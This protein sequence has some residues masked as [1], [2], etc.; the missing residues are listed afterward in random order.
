MTVLLRAVTEADI[1]AI[2]AINNSAVPAVPF[3]DEDGIADLVD[4]AALKLVAVPDENPAAVLGFVLAMSSGS[5][6]DSENFQWFERRGEAH[7]YVDRIVV[8]DGARGRGVGEALYAAV[9]EHAWSIGAGAVTCEVN[10]DPPNPGSLKFHGRLGFTEVGSQP[11]KG[12]AVT[13]A[14]LEH[15]PQRA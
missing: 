12:G 4:V 11:T 14:M 1:P 5:P 13:V 9:F 2:T 10:T 8:A 3:T 15:R 7:F 6:Y